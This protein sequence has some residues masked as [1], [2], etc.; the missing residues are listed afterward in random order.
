MNITKGILSRRTASIA[1]VL[2]TTMLQPIAVSAADPTDIAISGLEFG[3]SIGNL[4]WVANDGRSHVTQHQANQYEKLA[5]SVKE[6]IELG[7]AGSSLVRA[8][9]NVIGTTL[10]YA[11]VVDPEPVSKAITG[12]AAWGSKKTGDWIGQ[13][14]IEESQQQAQRILVEGLK[15]SGL[16]D[17]ALKNTTA[18][19]LKSMVADL[20]IGGETLREILKDDSD[21]LA[22]L[23]AHAAD[24]AARIGVEV[25]AK[26]EG[27][28]AD[29]QTLRAALSKT[30]QNIA[31]YQKEAS[32]HLEKLDKRLVK[33]DEATRIAKTK[34]DELRKEVGD[35]SDA[36][37]ALAQA[38]YSGWTTAQ[39]LQAVEGG[40]FPTLKPS[41]KTALV[42]SLKADRFREQA[43]YGINKAAQEFGALASI[44]TNIG[45][46]PNT[47]KSLQRA[48]VVASGIAQ[49]A[50]GNYLGAISSAT[51]L[52]GLGS[53]DAAAERHKAM[54]EYLQQQFEVINKKLD[55]I[56]DLQ[57][58]TIK[59]VN[60]LTREQREFRRDVL[61]QLDRI[62]NTVLRSE[63]ILQ[64]V[65]LSQWKDCHAFINGTP[66]N[67]QFTIPSR[68]VLAE[69]AGHP[70]AG[71]YAAK[72]YDQ[73]I[74]FLDAWVK[75]ATWSGQIISAGNF[76]AAAIAGNV[77]LQKDWA[78]YQT[79][80]TMAYTAA[81]DFVV[82]ARPDAAALPAPYLARL[83]Q[84]VVNASFGAQLK[85][86]FQR[87]DVDE[88]LR[89]FNCNQTSALSPALRDLICFG[90]VDGS[91][92]P[93]LK[94]RWTELLAAALIGPQSMRLIDT[95]IVLAALGDFAKRSD[96]GSFTFV[97]R[98]EIEN[99]SKAGM[100]PALRTALD[101]H[102]GKS[103][104]TKLRWLTEANVLQQ[105]ITYGDY[106]AEL[107]EETLYDQ[108]T[109]SLNIDEKALT[110]LKQKALFAMQVNPILAR[111]VVLLA[112]RHAIE[113]SLGGSAKAEPANYNQ[114]YYGLALQ[115]FAT[116]LG[117]NGSG[118]SA[119]K[120]KGLF[121]NWRF[122]YRV[123]KTQKQEQDALSKC[124]IEYEPD[125]NKIDSQPPA[126]GAGAA[127][128]LGNFY[129][130]VPAPLVLSSGAFEPSDSLR[131]ALIYR[132]RLSQAIIDR[133]IGE[134]VSILRANPGE[135][136][137][138]T[139]LREVAFGLVNEGWDWKTRRK[140]N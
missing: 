55:K 129:V 140:S 32:N 21:S 14:V 90:L 128:S 17:E 61:G 134:T 2:S 16:S 42:E 29:V 41:Q 81:R 78:A 4:L 71:A 77:N 132:D 69:V 9:F 47:V 51:S 102:K 99:F 107:I 40:L 64:A 112:M 121:P 94:E 18:S 34:F 110:P 125:P 101:Q 114:T 66:L 12:F 76:P 11:A 93:P 56:I 123:S 15:N 139:D 113:D 30:R 118:H 63:Q 37:R 98:E 24:I 52:V 88:P 20:K 111:N 126:M 23:Q 28:A 85:S 137:S 58:Q 122:E 8:N 50:T 135:P 36:A 82:Q 116:P 72:C 120:L 49:F 31:E 39:K 65:L 100:T 38:S 91:N 97:S 83:S 92:N 79:Q 89:L 26:T 75:P 46:P 96:D 33:L 43:V 80:R 131:L 60:D 124:P 13:Q 117:C 44:A 7:R 54:M 106:T 45:L 27:T 73:M 109:K 25:L 62:E 10:M 130:L 105:S 59:A 108:G 53:P 48:Q 127:V 1:V 22:M 104:L 115:D 19:D 87:K 84:P 74:G 136:S 3:G 103:L 6:Q 68:G 133:N 86:V 35:K 67:G 57:I 70:N 138:E 5:F 119:D 95:G